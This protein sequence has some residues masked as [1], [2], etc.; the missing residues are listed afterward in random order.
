MFTG[1]TSGTWQ[2]NSLDITSMV[3]PGG[4][5]QLRFATD[6]CCYYQEIGADNVSIMADVPEP[7]S[8]ALLGGTLVT[9]GAAR[10]RRR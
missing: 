5:F 3:A 7:A 8:F 10:R 1:T 6:T 2:Y 9:M 4:S